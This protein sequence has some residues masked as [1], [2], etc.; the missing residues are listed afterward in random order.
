MHGMRILVKKKYKIV[1]AN[2]VTPIFYTKCSCKQPIKK[3]TYKQGW[4]DR[5]GDKGNQKAIRATIPLP[6]VA[7]RVP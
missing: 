1:K 7:S 3:K 6:P 4:K 5:K 2:Y